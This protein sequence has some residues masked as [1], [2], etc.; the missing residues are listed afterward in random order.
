MR[1]L[2]ASPSAATPISG[3]EAALRLQHPPCLSSL[4]SKDLCRG[5]LRTFQGFNPGAQGQGLHDRRLTQS[6]G[7][8]SSVV[9]RTRGHTLHSV[10]ASPL[11]GAVQGW[12]HFVS[13]SHAGPRHWLM[14][15]HT[16]AH[17]HTCA[18]AP[19]LSLWP[20]G[21]QDP[22]R[23]G[24]EGEWTISPAD[25]AGGADMACWSLAVWSRVGAAGGCLAA[26]PRPPTCI[27]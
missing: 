25:A 26:R 10:P 27:P 17:I 16:R 2:P 13:H 20:V 24:V 3:T 18:H 5:V 11:P 4:L 12:P 14:Q 23:P 19:T 21:G 7:P 9:G 15:R 6:P 8:Q 1:N 22:S